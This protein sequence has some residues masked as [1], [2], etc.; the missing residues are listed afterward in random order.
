MVLCSSYYYYYYY[1][2]NYYYHQY[3]Q[4]PIRDSNMWNVWPRRNHQHPYPHS[5]HRIPPSQQQQQQPQQKSSSSSSVSSD[6]LVVG[7]ISLLV[8]TC[9]VST[10]LMSKMIALTTSSS[11]H[12]RQMPPKTTHVWNTL[13]IIISRYKISNQ[14]EN[15]NTAQLRSS[16]SSP[17]LLLRRKQQHLP[18][19][20]QQRQ[21]YEF[22]TPNIRDCAASGLLETCPYYVMNNNSTTTNNN[23]N[24]NDNLFDG[25][26]PS[27]L[28]QMITDNWCYNGEKEVCCGLS[29]DDC[30]EIATSYVA[31]FFLLALIVTS[32]VFI[33][34]ICAY[35]RCCIWYP[36]LWNATSHRGCGTL[37]PSHA[38]V[39]E[40]NDKGR[41]QPLPLPPIQK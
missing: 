3:P 33:V 31:L 27:N 23:S 11:S 35:G 21:L 18:P 37:R 36:K 8:L 26:C 15:D 29:S 32:P 14:N 7:T 1:C 24:N 25:T 39:L 28:Q 30:C 4:P 20:Q 17:P 5:Y 13:D 10:I 6:W 12:T 22:V 41:C 2:L 16:S 19:Q 34:C 9:I 40:E 38:E